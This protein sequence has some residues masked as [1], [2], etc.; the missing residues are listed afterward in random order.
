[1]GC[2][3]DAT[4]S[5]SNAHDDS[6]SHLQRRSPSDWYRHPV[7]FRRITNNHVQNFNQLGKTDLRWQGLGFEIK[8]TTLQMKQMTV[9]AAK[10]GDRLA[11]KA[12]P[13]IHKNMKTT[14]KC[15]QDEKHKLKVFIHRMKRQSPCNVIE[16]TLQL[17]S[18]DRECI[19]IA[20]LMGGYIFCH[21]DKVSLLLAPF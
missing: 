21:P 7:R 12:C 8:E 15:K 5:K 19:T 4:E 11:S 14:I 1:M 18:G 9:T 6:N 10:S 2:K 20:S 16:V 13:E 17:P 3:G